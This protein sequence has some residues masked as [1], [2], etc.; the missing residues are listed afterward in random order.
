[1]GRRDSMIDDEALQTTLI[2][3]D[4]PA[5]VGERPLK[6]KRLKPYS[7]DECEVTFRS[8]GGQKVHIDSVHLGLRPFKC[9]LLYTFDASY[10]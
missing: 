2:M 3:E 7:C 5:P 9:C 8:P 1:M 10:A 4:P 6:R